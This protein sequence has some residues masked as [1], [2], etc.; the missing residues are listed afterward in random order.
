MTAGGSTLKCAV[1]RAVDLPRD[2]LTPAGGN[3][4]YDLLYAVCDCVFSELLT[5]KM[6]IS[7]AGILT[8]THTHACMHAD[9]MHTL[10][11][12]YI[13]K[14]DEFVCPPNIIETVA[15]KI[16]KLAHRP[17]IA[18]TTIKLISKPILLS[19]LSILLKTI[20]RIGADPKRKSSPPFV[21]L[22]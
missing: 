6:H 9:K 7:N 12:I 4:S 22:R 5:S 15:V 20:Q 17:R 8:T 13:T 1:F 2:L 18:S 19:I 10:V 16:M 21:C 11:L 14:I 3:K